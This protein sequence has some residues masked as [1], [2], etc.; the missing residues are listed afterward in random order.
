MKAALVGCHGQTVYHQGAADKYLGK[1]LRVT[2][3]MGEAAVIAER[4]RV[5]VVSDFRPADLAAGGQG[6]PLVPIV[7]L[8]YV[9]L[10]ESKPGAAESG[11]DWESNGDSGRG[12]GGWGDG[13]RYGTGEHGDRWMHEAFV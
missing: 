11:R 3:Q 7:G 1:P 2:W 9:P 13:V 10:G 6:A 12:W 8:L 4:L 5:P